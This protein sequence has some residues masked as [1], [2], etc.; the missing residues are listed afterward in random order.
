M[1]SKVSIL[2]VETELLGRDIHRALERTQ[3]RGGLSVPQLRRD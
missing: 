2:C 1:I 3:E